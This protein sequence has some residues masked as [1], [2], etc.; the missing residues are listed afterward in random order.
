LRSLLLLLLC[1]RRRR[2]SFSLSFFAAL[3][4]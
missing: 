3:Q 2:P 1:N 4:V